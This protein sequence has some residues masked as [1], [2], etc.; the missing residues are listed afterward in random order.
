W[1]SLPGILLLLAK[2]QL[3]EQIQKG[4][5]QIKKAADR[6]SS[7]TKQLL[8]F[9]RRQIVQPKILDLNSVVVGVEDMLR[10]LISEDIELKIVCHPELWSV[11][12]DAGR[13]QKVTMNLVVNAPVAHA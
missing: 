6:A 11:N 8:I 12:V 3:T 5:S 7:L 10:R 2:S 13:L 1:G 4:L 9:S